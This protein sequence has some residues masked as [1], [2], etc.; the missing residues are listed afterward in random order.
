MT[1]HG[2]RRLRL[3]TEAGRRPVDRVLIATIVFLGLGL[4][5]L[6]VYVAVVLV[7][8][9]VPS[10]GERGAAA[11]S[12]ATAM[13]AVVVASP[14]RRRLVRGATWLVQGTRD[15]PEQ[16]LTTF[17]SR[18]SRTVPLDELLLQLAESLV[19]SLDLVAAEVWTLDDRQHLVLAAG[20]PALTRSPIAMSNEEASVL[21][22]AGVS[23]DAWIRM[24]I[25]TLADHHEGQ[26]VRVAPISHLGTAFGIIVIARRSPSTPFGEYEDAVLRDLAQPLGLVLHN[27]TLDSAL[28]ATNEELR[29]RNRELEESRRRLVTAADDARRALE[30]DLHDGAQQHLVAIGMKLAVL[31][32]KSMPQAATEELVAALQSDIEHTMDELR[33]L[34]HGLYPP[35]LR[36]HGL[37]DALRAA[38]YRSPQP[39]TVIDGGITRYSNEVESAVYFCC[40]EALQNAAKHAGPDAEIT[41]RLE[42]FD[43]GLRFQVTDDGTGFDRDRAAPSH[44]FQNMA[45]RMGAIGGSLSIAS[46]PGAGTVISGTVDTTVGRPPQR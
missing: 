6:V 2:R 33:E 44:G 37:A 5:V 42:P 28:A 10:S 29:Q 11:L 12:L 15:V 3:T 13:T 17:T 1:G 16:T 14:T 19:R 18:M 23:G 38:N 4:M 22:T 43:D 8:G 7:A 36:D 26:L 31:A 34:A 46:E 32:Q 25:P 35:V 21:C 9:R 39:C 41:I 24:W 20:V 40:L 27:A 30:R 45:D